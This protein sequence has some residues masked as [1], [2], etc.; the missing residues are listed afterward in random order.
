MRAFQK[1]VTRGSSIGVNLPRPM[2]CILGWLPGEHIVVELLEDKSVLLRR[3][4]ERDIMS[5]RNPR[6]VFGGLPEVA[7]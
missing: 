6:V 2:L 7:K 1:I 4:N 5:Q 3:L